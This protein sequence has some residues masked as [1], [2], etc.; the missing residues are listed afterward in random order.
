MNNIVAIIQ[1]R[2]SSTRFP[3]KVF[4]DLCG[5]PLIWHVFNRIQS[6]R[7]INSFILSTTNNELDNSL[8]DWAKDNNTLYFRGDENNVLK[9][10][11]DTAKYYKADIIVRITSDDPFKDIEIIDN[12]ISLLI[13][14]E[15]DFAYNNNPP[16]F[17]EGMDVE[18]FTFDA[19]EKAYFQ[20]ND[21]F[22]KEHVT[23]FFHKNVKLF[24]MK[25]LSF[26]ENLSNYRWTIDTKLD[27]EM[28]R[29]VY[30]KLY[31]VNKI[32]KMNDIL[33]LIVNHPE[34]PL[35]NQFVERSQ[36]Y[37]KL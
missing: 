10:Y 2:T 33:N 11:F 25:N 29:L 4:A 7:F 34:I 24:N 36:M 32:F 37:K 28:T 6:S 12:V 35:M 17:P 16:T 21:D 3:N 19:L 23:Q 8:V 30:N 15:L 22:E 9:R 18:V 31:N 5:K 20:C 1:A 13:I 26:K 27:F 14:N